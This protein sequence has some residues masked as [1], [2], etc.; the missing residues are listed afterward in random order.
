MHKKYTRF[1]FLSNSKRC[2]KLLSVVSVQISSVGEKWKSGVG[3]KRSQH[4]KHGT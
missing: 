3:S 4:A 1:G 2:L